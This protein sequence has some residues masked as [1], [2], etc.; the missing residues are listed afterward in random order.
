MKTKLR[1]PKARRVCL[2]EG[3]TSTFLP[4]E[5]ARAGD[6]PGVFVPDDPETL[7]RVARAIYGSYRA[8]HPFGKI[9]PDWEKTTPGKRAMATWHARAALRAVS[10][11]LKGEK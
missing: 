8:H 6:I 2:M 7:E 5:V 9:A 4:G 10:P 3:T 1:P 11:L